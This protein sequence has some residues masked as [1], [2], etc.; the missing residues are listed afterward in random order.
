MPQTVGSK[1]NEVYNKY[2]EITKEEWN[3]EKKINTTKVSILVQ[4]K[5][6]QYQNWDAI[7]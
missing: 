7:E 4:K 5:S 3:R 2:N 6:L 1:P